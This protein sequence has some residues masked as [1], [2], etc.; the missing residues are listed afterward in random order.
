MSYRE[1][2][3]Q[4]ANLTMDEIIANCRAHLPANYKQHPYRH[5]ELNHGLDLLRSDAALDCYMVAYGE[6]HQSKCRAALQNI[7][8]PPPGNSGSLAV[9]IIDWGCGQ[10]IGS[11]CVIDFLKDRDLT[12][13]LKRV[14]LIDP[15]APALE[16][17]QANVTRATAGGVRVVA[18][19]EYLPAVGSADE[20]ANVQ[21]EY[22]YVFHVFS[23][24]L[25][26]PE[27]DLAKLACCLAVPAHTHY[28]LCTGPKN[29]N[30]FRIDRF[31]DIF[32][33]KSYFSNIT[34]G[35][36]GNT[37]DTNYGFSC[38]SKAFVYHG[39]P[40]DLSKY[41]PAEKATQQAFGE[42]DVNLLIANG[43]LS[44]A[45]AWAYYRLQNVLG[46]NDLLYLDPEINGIVPDFIVVRPNVGMIVVS[47]FEENLANC[48]IGTDGSKENMPV[49]FVAQ[50]S[51]PAKMISSPLLVI[52]NYQNQL[53]ENFGELTAAVIRDNRNLGVVK[54]VLICSGGTTAQAKAL[55]GKANY[56]AVYGG[57]FLRDASVSRRMAD[58]LRFNYANHVFDNVVLSRL[59]RELS[60]RWHSYRE[61][62]EVRLT[63]QQRALA[64]SEEGAQR[65]ISGVAGSGKTQ[66]MATR[67][68]NAQVRTGGRVL[69]LTFNITL[70]NYLRMRMG[71]VRA[72]FRWDGIN[73]DYYHRFF[74]K[75][76]NATNLHVRF[77]S[78]DDPDFFNDVTARLPKF[79]AIFVDEVQDYKTEWL[80]LLQNHF[81]RPGGEF[82]VFGD[83]KQNI[84]KR[85]L[86]SEGNVRLGVISGVW[87]KSLTKGQRFTNPALASLAMAF[88]QAYLGQSDSIETSDVAAVP[89]SG[90]RFN[91]IEYGYVDHSDPEQ[92]IAIPVYQMCKR[93]IET[94]RLDLSKVAIVA[95]QIAI[96]RRID[97]LYR[98]DTGQDTT[99]SFVKQELLDQISRQS[100]LA[101]Y[102]YKRDVDRLEKVFKCRFTMDTR[103][104]TL[105]TI[106]SFKG[107]EANTIICII[108]SEWYGDTQVSSSPQMV[109]TGITRA[110][111]NLLVINVGDQK[112]HQFFQQR[113]Q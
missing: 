39:G 27:I 76:A 101:T 50:G 26:V 6:M 86:D 22:D 8:Y 20:I 11:V 2:I 57:E 82:V 63:R 12:R 29:A 24:I 71:Q 40:L 80:R 56:V 21:I 107:W 62:V 34:T 67:A 53:I 38:K 108:L 28:V 33:P 9:E 5:P 89:D 109:Y 98:A 87:N 110:K 83:P 3:S 99:L 66:V 42:Y 54:K 79:D 52:D 61:G 75:Y 55:F 35:R 51:A 102:G 78:Y 48:R 16:R 10:G 112:Y 23:N 77:N 103:N 70:A 64:Q 30:A 106:Q 7:P 72:D 1:R 96:L 92:D 19:N 97:S 44:A 94:N 85:E 68:V 58:D 84:Y 15:S 104:L 47:V 36:L 88:Q 49:V 74:R 37:S 69:L 93:F 25:D 91:I 81:L 105:S 65:K 46:P 18:I 4:I 43:S 17:A 13:W 111:E 32:Q 59:K 90:F 45:K 100:S 31:C 41:N 73:I 60:P 95:P 14:T 113:T